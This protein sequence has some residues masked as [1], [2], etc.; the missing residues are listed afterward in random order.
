ML[1]PK[2]APAIIGDGDSVVAILPGEWNHC[3]YIKADARLI[4][5]APDSHMACLA[6]VEALREHFKIPHE[7][8][9]DFIYDELGS[10]L[11][12]AYFLA[13]GSVKKATQP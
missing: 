7:A 5:S 8:D 6:T 4:A 2:N 10:T 12:Y 1:N 13:R 9:D 3:S 11:S